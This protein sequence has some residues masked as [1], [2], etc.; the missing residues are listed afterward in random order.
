MGNMWIALGYEGIAMDNLLLLMT[1]LMI[2]LMSCVQDTDGT[3]W[4]SGRTEEEARE[5]AAKQFNVDASKIVLRQ[6][7]ANFTFQQL[8]RRDICHC[9]ETF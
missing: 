3:Y 8:S 7:E 9:F 1:M 2:M 5:K 4:V 6:G